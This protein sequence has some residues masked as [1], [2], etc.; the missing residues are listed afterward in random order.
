MRVTLYYYGGFAEDCL[1]NRKNTEG[2]S[3]YAKK[4]R[5]NRRGFRERRRLRAN[6]TDNEN[7]EP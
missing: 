3:E 1:L 4:D 6:L 7:G 2:A 5:S